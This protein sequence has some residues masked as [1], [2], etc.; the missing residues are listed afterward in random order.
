MLK[1]SLRII[2]GKILDS[3][4]LCAESDYSLSPYHKKKLICIASYKCPSTTKVPGII[5]IT[6]TAVTDS[7]L[8]LSKVEEIK[9][10]RLESHFVQLLVLGRMWL[11]TCHFYKFVDE[12]ELIG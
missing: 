1:A 9:F 12:R 5:H 7:I 11:E 2:H 6:F 3:C 4:N 8:I 10:S